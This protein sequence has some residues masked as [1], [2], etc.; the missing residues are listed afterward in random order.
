MLKFEGF[1]QVSSIFAKVSIER[2]PTAG[3]GGTMLD[4]GRIDELR[5]DFG[6]EDFEE[7]VG[8]FL[9]EVDQCLTKITA[10]NCADIQDHLHFL[11]GSA[12]NLGFV[13]VKK[14]CETA[15]HDPSAEN[16]FA[17]AA[18]FDISI[19]AFFEIEEPASMAA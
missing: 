10:P 2:V 13:L 17:V 15:E 8:L 16:L 12:A 4:M 1:Y 5:N 7:I 18:Q 6:E 3:N 14:A 11:K 9:K 19:E